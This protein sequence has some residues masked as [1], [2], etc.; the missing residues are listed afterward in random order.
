VNSERDPNSPVRHGQGEGKGEGMEST[1]RTALSAGVLFIVATAASLLSTAMEQPVLTGPDYLSRVA[2]N[3]NRVSAGALLELVA[4]GTSAGIAISLY[5]VLRRWSTGLALGSV[6]FRAMEAVM[7]TVGAVSMLSLP[8]V[9]QQFTRTTA[10]H[11]AVQAIGDSLL[12]F[13]EEAILAGVF[14]FVVGA[15][16]Y[17]YLLYRS[18]LVPRWLSSWGLGAVLLMLVACLSALF[19]RNPVTSYA[20]LIVPI[21]LQEMVLAVWLLAKG[22]SPTALASGVA[23][24]AG[25]AI[26]RQ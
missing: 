12:A 3:V 16:M 14:A 4:A 7:Y 23:L 26:S 2:E 17:Y 13:R 20:I 25:K 19:S 6:L 15:F 21:A 22:F 1:R 24:A 10:D 11:A 18:R 5:P 9:G 8:E